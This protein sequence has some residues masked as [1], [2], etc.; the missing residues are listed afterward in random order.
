MEQQTQNMAGRICPR[1]ASY[2][3]WRSGDT[4]ASVARMNA[5]TVQAIRLINEDINFQTISPGTEIC[6]P[7][8]SLTCQSGQPYTIQ[9]GDTLAAIAQRLGVTELSLSERNPDVN[10]NDLRPGDVICVPADAGDSG[11]VLD[12]TGQDNNT[13]TPQR[14]LQPITP[15]RPTPACPIGY[16][17]QRVRA[18]QS[19]ADLL[20]DLNVSYK[21]MRNANPTLRPGY[22][23][24]GTAYC[25]PPAGTRE[26]CS[27]SRNYSIQDGDTLAGIARRLNTTA[28][29]LLMLNP[30][31]L[32][33][34]FSQVGVVIC[35]P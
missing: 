3:I 25:A 10:A 28:G 14:P 27:G 21:A 13:V 20:I 6:L 34:D 5:T 32:P 11:P 8:R 29:R 31:L 22:M 35:I 17:A 30:T 1:G 15:S 2:Y 18:G 23:V 33:T 4:I 26:T 9:A 24:A 16:S 19:Y 7:S 12:G